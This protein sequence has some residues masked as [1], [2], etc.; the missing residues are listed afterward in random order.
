MVEV[1]PVR[2]GAALAVVPAMGIGSVLEGRGAAVD[3]LHMRAGPGARVAVGLGPVAP[4]PVGAVP[5][6]EHVADLMD[7]RVE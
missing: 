6:A 4:I 3:G 5:G 1:D 7:H 2:I